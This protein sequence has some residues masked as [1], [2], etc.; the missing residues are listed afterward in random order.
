MSRLGKSRFNASAADCANND[1]LLSCWRLDSPMLDDWL[2]GGSNPSGAA[3]LRT[4]PGACDG[5]TRL[6][7]VRVVVSAND[8][9]MC[10]IATIRR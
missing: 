8:S 2:S 5:P 4:G 9:A 7:I 10:L 3:R 6:S 1:E